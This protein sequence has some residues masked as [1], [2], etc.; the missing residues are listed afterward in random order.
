MS[1]RAENFVL[2]T[3]TMEL[4]TVTLWAVGPRMRVILQSIPN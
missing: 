1:L 2:N 3:Q 4:W